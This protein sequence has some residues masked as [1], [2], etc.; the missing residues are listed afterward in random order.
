MTVSYSLVTGLVSS[1]SPPHCHALEVLRVGDGVETADTEPVTALDCQMLAKVCLVPDGGDDSG[2]PQC[3]SIH[4]CHSCTDRFYL[5]FWLAVKKQH[6][7]SS[8]LLTA[9]VEVAIA[10]CLYCERCRFESYRLLFYFGMYVFVVTV[11]VLERACVCVQVR[12]LTLQTG[13]FSRTEAKFKAGGAPAPP[14]KC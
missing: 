13:T 12:V 2:P 11:V 9:L 14:I 10:I 5:L 7:I 3:F 1:C 8:R 4:V 6:V